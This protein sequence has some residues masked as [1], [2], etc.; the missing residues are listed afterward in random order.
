[1]EIGT[2]HPVDLC[3][4]LQWQAGAAG[5][6]DGAVG[7]FLRRDPSQKPEIVPLW[8]RRRQVQ[9]GGQTMLNGSVPVRISQRAALMVRD[10]NQWKFRPASIGA[11]EILQVQPAVQRRDCAPGML[12]KD[13][14]MQH[15]HMEM[16]DVEFR[17]P[18]VQLV[19][20]AQVRREVRLELARIE[21]DRPVSAD[22]QIRARLGFRAGE[23]GDLV[24]ELDK[25]IGKI[26]H[27]ALGPAIETRRHRFVEGSDLR[28]PHR[29]NSR[30]DSPVAGAIAPTLSAGTLGLLVCRDAEAPRIDAPTN[31]ELRCAFLE[32]CFVLSRTRAASVIAAGTVLPCDWH[33]RR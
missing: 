24:A 31:G 27:D 3:G 14:E 20:H 6:L 9:I 32:R 33:S 16:D 21:P 22:D 15:V 26:G 4:D 1:M 28:N 23:Q 7:P 10:R 13:R 30:Q 11:V 29:P 19:Q 5:N 17:R 18:F 25:G 2:V 12:G 8:P